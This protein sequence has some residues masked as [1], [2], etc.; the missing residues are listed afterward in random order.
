M[1]GTSVA[2]LALDVRT[3]PLLREFGKA[4]GQPS[5][6]QGGQD[7][8]DNS[9]SMPQRIAESAEDVVAFW[10]AEGRREQ[11]FRGGPAFDRLV[12]EVLGPAYGKAAEGAF[13]NWAG[14]PQ[15]ALALVLLLDQVPRNMFRS[16]PQAF[17][18]DATARR[19]THAAVEAGF[20]KGLSQVERLFL[21][22]P[23]EHSE[24]IDD[25]ELG[26]RL[27]AE[28]AEDPDWLDYARQHRDVIARFG[29]FP[30][31]NAVLGRPC[32]PEEEA[33]LKEPGSS[34]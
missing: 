16:S 1:L 31:R 10:F 14:S 11:W 22:M 2:V 8:Q 19:V 12:E 24:A 25:Q 34:F 3:L 26:C 9:F 6:A 28:L 18:T 27:M 20:D 21:Y 4:P 32:T 23:L 29:R 15:G 5:G 13:E 7:R 30:H 33:F 17:A